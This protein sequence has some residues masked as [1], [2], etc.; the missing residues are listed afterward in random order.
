VI[1]PPP[2]FVKEVHFLTSNSARSPAMSSFS[3]SRSQFLKQSANE[4]ADGVIETDPSIMDGYDPDVALAQHLVH[5]CGTPTPWALD[6]LAT[7]NQ[8]RDAS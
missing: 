4:T 7:H 8:D 2:S 5:D 3:P 1:K 6:V